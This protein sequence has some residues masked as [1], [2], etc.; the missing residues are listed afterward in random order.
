[1]TLQAPDKT[2]FSELYLGRTTVI[3]LSEMYFVS[4]QTIAKWVRD[5]GICKVGKYILKEDIEKLL[6]KGL[7]QKEMSKELNCSKPTLI[8]YLKKYELQEEKHET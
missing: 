2:E 5:F 3:E 4:T 6:G 7:T 8:T 1:M